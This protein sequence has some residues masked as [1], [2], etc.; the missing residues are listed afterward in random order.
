M[1]STRQ[2]GFIKGR[3]TT[4]QL[5]TYLDEVAEFL[6][7]GKARGAVDVV[8]LDYQKAFDTVPHRRLIHKLRAYGIT[9]STL[10]WIES[11]LSERTQRVAVHGTLSDERVVLS[12]VPQGSVLGPLLF[13]LYINDNS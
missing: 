13:L 3:S 11:F 2:F 1:L 7:Q 8:Y 5:L 10:G 4:L 12:G 6:A 9:G